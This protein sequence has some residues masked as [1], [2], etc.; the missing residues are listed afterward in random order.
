M[1]GI[2]LYKVS[3]KSV[4]ARVAPGVEAQTYLKVAAAAG[5]VGWYPNWLAPLFVTAAPKLS[6][7]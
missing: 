5:V 2:L 3:L 1:L 4:A 6:D 7:G